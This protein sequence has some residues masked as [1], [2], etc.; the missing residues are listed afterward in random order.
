MSRLAFAI[1]AQHQKRIWDELTVGSNVLDYR[2]SGVM[3]LS[4]EVLKMLKSLFVLI[5]DLADLE[6]HEVDCQSDCS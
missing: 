4:N 1:L 6:S 3:M 5:D 2:I